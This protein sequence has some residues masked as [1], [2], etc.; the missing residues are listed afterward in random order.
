MNRTKLFY[1]FI[2]VM[3]SLPLLTLHHSSEPVKEK[4]QGCVFRTVFEGEGIDSALYLKTPEKVELSLTSS[5]DWISKAQNKDGG[6]GAGWH[7]KQSEF[8]PHAVKSDPATT[9]ITTMA[10][11][12]MG[13]T[14]FTGKY[15]ANVALAT[16]YLLKQVEQTPSN[17]TNITTLTGTQPQVKLGQNIDVVLTAQYLTNLMDYLN[18]NNTMKSRVRKNLDV[19]VAKIQQGINPN[20]SLQGSGW[21]GVLQSSFAANALET[22]MQAGAKVDTV[23][24]EKSRSYLKGNYNKDTKSAVTTDA[25]GVMLYSISGTAR[26]SSAEARIARE[27]IAKAKKDGILAPTEEVTAKNLQAAGMTAADA[28]KYAAAYEINRAAARQAQQ[29]DVMNG[30]GSNGGEE[31]LSYLQTGEGMIMSKDDGWKKWYDNVSGRLMS[32]QNNDG[33]WNGHHC[34]TSPVFCT[35]TAVLI[36]SVN[37]DIDRLL[38]VKEQHQQN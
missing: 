19:C 1:A 2:P 7:S 36:L 37:R 14:P 5:L 25:A 20:G 27:K 6:W 38:A 4:A 10:L 34:I 24:L 15:S 28:D 35:A 31:F 11:L 8:D 18:N 12:R 23:K 30:F 17:S 3:A 9:A 22:A 16:E 32:I 21:A 13:N 26:S 29:N 33:S